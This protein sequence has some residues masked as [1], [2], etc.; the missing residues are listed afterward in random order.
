[1]RLNRPVEHLERDAPVVNRFLIDNMLRYGLFVGWHYSCGSVHDSAFWRYARDRA[2]P[3]HREAA[4][5][6]AAGCAALS[7]FD[8]MIELLNRPVID[9]ADWDRMCGVPLTSYAQMSQGLGV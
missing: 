8:D 7:K 5:P 3:Q 9:K 4:N 6:R 2:W 1:M